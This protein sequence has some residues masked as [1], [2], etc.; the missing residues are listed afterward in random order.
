MLSRLLRELLF[1]IV[2]L[3]LSLLVAVQN[4][5]RRFRRDKW[6]EPE[7]NVTKNDIK[8]ILD[9]IPRDQ[10]KLK[11]LVVIA[12]TDRHSLSDF[13]KLLIWSLVAGVPYLSFYDIS[14]IILLIL[15]PQ[16]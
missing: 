9:S 15:N 10:S 6:N 2:H 1:N 13:A 7:E 12:D 5:Y 3:V 11:H 4:V 8:L 14:G 16:V